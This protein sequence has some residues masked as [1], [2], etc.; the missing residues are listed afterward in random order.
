MVLSFLNEGVPIHGVGFQMH[1]SLNWYPEKRTDQLGFMWEFLTNMVRLSELGLEVHFTEMDVAIKD[2]ENINV[3]KRVRQANIYRDMLQVGLC[4]ENFTVFGLW[5]F[6]DKHS[7]IP[8]FFSTMYDEEYGAA[9]I[10]DENY[11]PKLPYYAIRDLLE[12]SGDSDG[13][14]LPN[15]LEILRG[16]DPF[17]E[18]T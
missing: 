11:D 12:N 1:W 6:T 13:D 10:F 16:T 8:W 14:G 17:A 7:W 4:A 15:C 3:T 2:P 18:N 5:G 9:L